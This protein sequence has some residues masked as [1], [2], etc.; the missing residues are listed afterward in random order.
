MC[1]FRKEII[2]DQDKLIGI[3]KAAIL[4][5]VHPDTLRQWEKNGQ[6]KSMRTKG[7]HRR[8]RV[9]D[10]KTAE[11]DNVKWDRFVELYKKYKSHELVLNEKGLNEWL[12]FCEDH[13]FALER[14][15]KTARSEIL[16]D[17]I[18][19]KYVLV[20]V[21]R[22]QMEKEYDLFWPDEDEHS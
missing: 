18:A 11:K 17:V 20:M 16:N 2:M 13:N 4:L 15:Q 9:A 5:G 1:N 14:A 22:E 6:I 12:Y 3:G 7:N 19:I 21:L 10:L 8:Y